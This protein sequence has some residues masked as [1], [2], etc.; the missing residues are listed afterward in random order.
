MD[1]SPGGVWRFCMH[2]P[3]GV[4]YENE[5]TYL[6]VVEPERIAYEHRGATTPGRSASGR[7]STFED[8]RRQDPAHHA[9]GLPDGRGTRDFVVEKYGADRG[10]RADL[11]RLGEFAAE[12]W[13][14]GTVTG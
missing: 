2:G 3:D 9:D 8:R 10:P 13:P 4:D 7:P 1:V 12:R 5:I 14:G 6:E 11:D